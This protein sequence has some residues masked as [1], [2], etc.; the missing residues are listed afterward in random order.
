MEQ[1]LDARAYFPRTR[2][3]GTG[4]LV[5]LQPT[6]FSATYLVRVDYAG[7]YHAP[8]VSVISPPIVG[9]PHHMYDGTY[10]CLYWREWDGTMGFGTTIVP[11][12]ARWLELYEVWQVTG[13]WH[14]PEAPLSVRKP[15]SP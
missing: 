11:W 2:W 15:G 13:H 12:A 14:A 10:L 6:P 1:Y 8:K 3:T 4:I 5:P 7:P 9:A